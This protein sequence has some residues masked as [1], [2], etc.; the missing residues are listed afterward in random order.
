MS[1]MQAI[2][3]HAVSTNSI[4]EIRFAHPPRNVAVIGVEPGMYVADFG[5]G[6]G[7]YVFAI[8][9]CLEN[10]GHVYAIDVQKDLLR[11]IA[12]EATQRGF[13]NVEVLWGDLESSGG[14]KLYDGSMDIVLISNLLF[15]VSDK[16]AFLSEA[17]RILKSV[18]RLAIIDWS[19]SFNGMGPIPE[20]VVTKEKALVLAK[21]AGFKL[22]KEFPAGAHHYELILRPGI[23][24]S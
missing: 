2:S 18:G 17:R 13:R 1:A 14:S 23:V 15:Q 11:R 19:D 12:N 9:E 22:E 21:K 20:D 24:Q 8:A 4:S 16:S 5:A 7:A 3:T 10:A 6:S